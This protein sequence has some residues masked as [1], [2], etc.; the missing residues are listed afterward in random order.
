MKR[1]C[2]YL[3]TWNDI[4]DCIFFLLYVLPVVIYV[5]VTDLSDTLSTYVIIIWLLAGVFQQVRR[6]YR[7]VEKL[8]GGIVLPP[9]LVDKMSLGKIQVTIEKLEG[10]DGVH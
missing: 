5:L 3:P 7:R 10:D 1:L 9:E 6:L 8:S 4:G 2:K